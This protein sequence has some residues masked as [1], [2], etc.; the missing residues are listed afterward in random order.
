MD[1]RRFIELMGRIKRGVKEIGDDFSLEDGGQ[2]FSDDYKSYFMG[3]KY[4]GEK[5]GAIVPYYE[6]IVFDSSSDNGLAEKV[7]EAFEGLLKTDIIP[8]RTGGEAS[9]VISSIVRER[10]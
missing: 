2:A 6:R 8:Y 5:F 10:E 3:L 7:S 9:L 1:D 4:K